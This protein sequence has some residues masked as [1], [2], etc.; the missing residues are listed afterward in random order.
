MAACWPLL[1]GFGMNWFIWTLLTPKSLTGCW[2]GTC[3]N[4]LE[5]WALCGCA[6]SCSD[7][8]SSVLLCLG[9]G[10][11]GS[12]LSCGEQRCA[13]SSSPAVTELISFL[14]SIFSGVGSSSSTSECF[15]EM[16]G[17]CFS[18]CACQVRAEGSLQPLH[19]RDCTALP[20][21]T[22]RQ[23]SLMLGRAE[24]RAASWCLDSWDWEELWAYWPRGNGL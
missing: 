12:K 3:G 6:I 15:P 13:R 21:V 22:S 2:W 7:C 17:S 16:P 24:S 1:G 5:H 19:Q 9:W 20:Q 14:Q 8:P 23:K 11:E 18:C 10:C 4:V